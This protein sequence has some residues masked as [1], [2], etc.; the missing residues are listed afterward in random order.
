MQTTKSAWWWIASRI[1][2][3]V[4]LWSPLV[5]F[6]TLSLGLKAVHAD[7]FVVLLKSSHVLPGLGELSLLHALSDVP[8]DE[9]TLG[10]HQV[11]LVVKPGPGLGDGGGVGEHAHG[12]LHLGQ[13]AAGHHGGRL[14]VDANLET[15]GAPVDELDAPLGLDGGNGGVD[16]LGDDVTPVEHA[17]GHV[18]AVPWVALHHLV[19]GLEAG[20]GDL[21]HTELLMV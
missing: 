12:A 17:A 6:S 18:L 11:E 5:F 1:K 4:F 19:G 2:Q 13:V 20:V 16:I 8:V 7:L 21:G 14:V 10:V 9:G 3:I 15:G